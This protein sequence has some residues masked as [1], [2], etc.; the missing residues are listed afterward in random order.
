MADYGLL[1]DLNKINLNA[2]PVI[3]KQLV[4]PCTI[5]D[6]L[7]IDVLKDYEVTFESEVTENPVETGFVVA[8]HVIR[9]PLT[10]RLTAIFTPTPVTFLKILGGLPNANRLQEV[11]SELARIYQNA[12]PVTVK[13]HDAI[14]DN[15]VM[16]TAPLKRNV[17][18]GICYQ[19]ELNFKHVVVVE[20]RTEKIPEEYA[21]NDAQ[22]KAGRTE[23]DAGTA[24]QKD[25]GTGM[26]TIANTATVDIVSL[27]S[28][29][30]VNGDI[31]TGLEVT[32]SIA[33]ASIASS[34]S[35]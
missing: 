15:M 32:A 8:D 1:N 3:P 35:L 7:Q 17:Q 25:I 34:I 29:Y 31:N 14:Y 24:E 2:I 4:A 30:L 23:S 19:M 12:D 6:N 11:A 27:M 18:D 22:G 16:T 33:A 10:L 5:G 20:Q 28:D 9:K 13:L 26:T 21:A